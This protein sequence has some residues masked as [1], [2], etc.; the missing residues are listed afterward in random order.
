MRILYIDIDSQRP[1]HLG[2]YGYHRNTTP[3]IDA[4]AREGVRFNGCYTSDAPCLPSRTA[5][6]SGRFGIQT[7]VVGHGGTVAEPKRQGPLHRGFRDLFDLQGL[8][9]QL[10]RAGFHTAMVSPFGQRHAAHWFYAGFHEIHNTGMGGMESAE[11]VMPA[12]R[13]WVAANASGD[14]WYLH[15]NFWDPHTPYRVPME[16]GEPFR[17]APLP[18]WLD[19]GELIARH[20]RKTG[21]H[22][23]MDLA[24]FDEYAPQDLQKY[25]RAVRRIDGRA[26]LKSWIDGYDTGTRYVDEQ[27]GWLVGE[28]K[29]LGVY[30]E[31]AIIVSADHGENQGELG[32]YGEHATADV[33]TCRV[34]LIIKWPGAR[35]GAVQDTLH[36]SVD[37]APTLMDLLG[38]D[39]CPVWD[40]RS[41]AGAIRDG[42]G[43]SEGREDLVLSQ[44]AHVLQRSVRWDRWLYMRTYHCGFHLF[45]REMVFDLVSDPHEQTDLAGSRPDLCREGAWRLADWHDNQ[46]QKMARWCT[47]SEDPLWTA[48]R[49]GGPYHAAHASLQPE[50]NP[51]PAYLSR[52]AATGRSGG[53]DALVRRYGEF[54]K[55]AH[56]RESPGWREAGPP[57]PP[58]S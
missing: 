25:P 49:E 4:I 17:D 39:P 10:Q 11:H 1:D 15:L 23:A 36:Y 30:D 37:L 33:A 8:A 19:D 50:M 32:I 38:R 22:S 51:L 54:L 56:G 48:M 12:L 42:A 5:L 40:G 55:R 28:L 46:M 21:P 9:G 13:K 31:T 3:A 2:C 26:A 24:M 14:R 16:F 6:Y 27:I 45:P 44:C 57:D 58:L 20:L 53:G 34:P 35:C 41:F 29:R 7:G 43:P 47:D 18:A 52:L